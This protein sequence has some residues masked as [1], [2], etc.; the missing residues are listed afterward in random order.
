MDTNISR[1][2]GCSVGAK[3][4]EVWKLVRNQLRIGERVP[5]RWWTV[6]KLG[7]HSSS[8]RTRTSSNSVRGVRSI[9]PASTLFT[10]YHK[11]LQ[12]ALW[13]SECDRPSNKIKFFC[14]FPRYRIGT[15]AH[16]S[17]FPVNGLALTSREH[18]PIDP[19]WSK[20]TSGGLTL[21]GIQWFANTVLLFR[22]FDRGLEAESPKTSYFGSWVVQCTQKNCVLRRTSDDV[23]EEFGRSDLQKTL[24]EGPSYSSLFCCSPF[25]YGSDGTRYVC[26]VNKYI[27]VWWIWTIMNVSG[28]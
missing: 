24:P 13:R 22:P 18:W 6:N 26:A 3:S 23:D 9:R 15:E 5:Y 12:G 27:H 17:N 21:T 2:I 19:N 16:E 28:F 25:R 14:F 7:S 20:T 10:K 11:R 4:R 1:K 8:K